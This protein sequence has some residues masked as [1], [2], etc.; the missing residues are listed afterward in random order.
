[1][2]GS[3]SGQGRVQ[4]AAPATGSPGEQPGTAGGRAAAGA[5]GPARPG[6]SEQRPGRLALGS[7]LALGNRG[8]RRG[9]GGRRGGVRRGQ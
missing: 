1:M 5:G 2:E 7:R 6:L 8:R 3:D 4:A 9:C